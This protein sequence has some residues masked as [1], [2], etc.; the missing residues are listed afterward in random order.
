MTWRRNT[1]YLLTNA[2]AL[3]SS[4]VDCWSLKHTAA[5]HWP[6]DALYRF[7]NVSG[8]M[9]VQL[10]TEQER[11]PTSL[12]VVARY[13]WMPSENCVKRALSSWLMKVCLTVKQAAKRVPGFLHGSHIWID[14]QRMTGKLKNHPV[15]KMHHKFSFW[16]RK[17]TTNLQASHLRFIKCTTNRVFADLTG[18]F[19]LP[20]LLKPYICAK[21]PRKYRHE[22]T[23]AQNVFSVIL[24]L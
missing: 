7:C 6:P 10:T 5:S 1:A 13:P 22:Y 24:A 8:A 12:A 20:H 17:L 11:Q 9:T 18:T 16:L 14:R 15:Q 19:Y 4:S 2:A 23:R 21:K 3:S